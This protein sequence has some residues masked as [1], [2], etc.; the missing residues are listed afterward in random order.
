MTNST[1]MLT[2][3]F[4]IWTKPRA[5]IQQV[6]DTNP[7]RFVLLLAA[8]AGVQ[9]GVVFGIAALGISTGAV[10][11]ALGMAVAGAVLSIAGLYIGSVLLHWI[12][13]KF[14]GRA[15][16]VQ[17]RAAIAW[18]LIPLICFNVLGILFGTL[19]GASLLIGTGGDFMVVMWGLI[20][21]A[22]GGWTFVLLIKCLQQIQGFSMWYALANVL[23]AGFILWIA[24]RLAV[25]IITTVWVTIMLSMGG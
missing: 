19:F 18:S 13:S 11:M 9:P 17:I 21:I 3:W 6:I 2:P 25:F 7:R 22:A 20:S 16:S 12:G 1:K 15:T 8:M 4:S 24:A 14:S 5:T 10:M 23:L